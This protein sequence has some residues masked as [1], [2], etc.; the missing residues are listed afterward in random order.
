MAV[1]EK[2]VTRE[3]L[4][5]RA[6]VGA[7]VLGAGSMLTASTAGADFPPSKECIEAWWLWLRPAAV[8]LSQP[9]RCFCLITTEG[10]CVCT[11]A[12]TARRVRGLHGFSSKQC[13]PGWACVRS[14]WRRRFGFPTACA[15]PAH[16]HA[17][18]VCTS[19]VRPALKGKNVQASS[20]EARNAGD[21]E[22]GLLQEAHFIVGRPDRR[23]RVC[24]DDGPEEGP[25]YQRGYV[26]ESVDLTRLRYR[27]P[28][29]PVIQYV[30]TSS[31]G[32]STSWPQPKNEYREDAC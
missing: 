5:K 13:P 18:D 8:W 20:S 24:S 3:R 27:R 21:R 6:G 31:G 4:L 32:F 22:V 17:G 11:R 25:S 28:P 29:P 19:D 14:A 26:R 23:R 30:S 15:P 7:A 12:S 9:Q 16:P 2:R 10:C 1:S